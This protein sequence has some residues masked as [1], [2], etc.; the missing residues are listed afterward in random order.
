MSASIAGTFMDAGGWH[1]LIATAALD[2]FYLH[3]ASSTVRPLPKLK[4]VAITAVGWNRH[5][6]TDTATAFILVGTRDGQLY[7]T[8]LNSQGDVAYWKKVWIDERDAFIDRCT[9]WPTRRRSSPFT[10][11]AAPTAVGCVW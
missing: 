2:N 8:Q 11:I 7:E 10:C 3:N 9:R 6:C 4:G 5:E 1:V